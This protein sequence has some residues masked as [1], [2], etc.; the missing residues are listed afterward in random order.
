MTVN[1]LR[2]RAGSG[3]RGQRSAG[4]GGSLKGHALG[5][6]HHDGR[7][8]LQVSVKVPVELVG[9]VGLELLRSLPQ[10]AVHA[11]PDGKL[12]EVLENNLNVC[13]Q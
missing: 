5:Q 6:L 7:T 12:E 13:Q 8:V 3:V 11:G 4:S 10:G 1:T 9:E 2:A